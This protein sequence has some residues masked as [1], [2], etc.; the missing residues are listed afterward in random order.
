MIDAPAFNDI[1]VVVIRDPQMRV[2]LFAHLVKRTKVTSDLI[3]L[4]YIFFMVTK[5][6]K[7]YVAE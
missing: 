2:V 6:S 4:L 5:M 7:Q 3:P 1:N